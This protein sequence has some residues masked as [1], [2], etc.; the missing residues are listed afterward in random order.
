MPGWGPSLFATLDECQEGSFGNDSL[1]PGGTQDA[2]MPTP[3]LTNDVYST[4][5]HRYNKLSMAEV[6]YRVQSFFAEDSE[7]TSILLK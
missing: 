3:P 1:K 4:L 7:A 5:M 6:D 2:L